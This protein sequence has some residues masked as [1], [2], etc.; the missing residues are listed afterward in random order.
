[1][2]R[3]YK[4]GDKL[5]P[6]VKSF[7]GVKDESEVKVVTQQKAEGKKVLNAR[8][9]YLLAEACE[10]GDILVGYIGAHP[11]LDLGQRAWAVVLSLLCQRA[12]YPE[13]VE[14]F[15]ELADQGGKDLQYSGPDNTL[16][17]E[18]AAAMVRNLPI[19]EDTRFEAAAQFAETFSAYITMKKQQ[20]GVSNPQGAYGLGRAFHNLRLGFPKSEGGSAVF[21]EYAKRAGRYYDDNK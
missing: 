13:G 18:E 6:T 3:P 8:E 17:E 19:L 15:D 14:K 10:F 11:S 20:L 4:K 16:P 21:D 7:L 12:D 2:I 1:M 9:Q 5:D